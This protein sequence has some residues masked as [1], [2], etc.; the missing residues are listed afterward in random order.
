M[1]DKWGDPCMIPTNK[2]IAILV[3]ARAVHDDEIREKHLFGLDAGKNIKLFAA[4]NHS[5]KQTVIFPL[6]MEQ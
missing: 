4:L 3:F 6:T 5:I 2:E 1:G